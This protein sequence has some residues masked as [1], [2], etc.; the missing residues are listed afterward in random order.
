MQGTSTLVF[1]DLGLFPTSSDYIENNDTESILATSGMANTKKSKVRKTELS[2]GSPV[3][4]LASSSMSEGRPTTAKSWRMSSQIHKNV[5]CTKARNF[6]CP[7][8]CWISRAETSPHRA[9]TRH[10]ANTDGMSE[11]SK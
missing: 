2:L 11:C 3:Q 1:P 7:G 6:T 5:D 10:S 9:P 8:Y 4:E